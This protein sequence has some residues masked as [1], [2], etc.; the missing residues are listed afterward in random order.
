MSWLSTFG[1]VQ[2]VN[3]TVFALATLALSGFWKPLMTAE[4]A[5]VTVGLVLWAVS[6]LNYVVLLAGKKALT[7][8]DLKPLA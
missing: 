5:V 6:I 1:G 3:L 4:H 7:S 2:W 8:A